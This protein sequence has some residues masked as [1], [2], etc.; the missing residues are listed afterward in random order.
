MD[1]VEVL[2]ATMNQKDH[3][4]LK[5]MNIQTE[6][7][8][9]NQCDRN[10]IEEFDFSGRKC[11]YLNFNERGVGLNRN[12][13]LMRA[14][15]D[16]CVFADDDMVFYDGYNEIVTEAFR[17]IE[18]AD[19]LIFNI[20]EDGQTTRRKNTR[21]K[22]IG[23]LNYLNYGAARI[24][25]RRQDV[26]YKGISFNLNFGGGTRH[27]CGE[28]T[29]FLRECLRKRV[30][31]YAVPVSIAKLVEKRQSTWFQG[32]NE[33]YFFDSGI[34]LSIAHPILCHLLA[35][36]FVLKHKEYRISE[37]DGRFPVIKAY[38]RGIFYSYKKKWRKS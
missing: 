5:T 15:G 12:N 7:I 31:I 4:L 14:A 9:A 19:V 37:I 21:T 33:K 29:L 10:L 22:R 16:F 36:Y 18:K 6:A 25:I 26:L 11:I 34:L 28:D 13:A 24:V 8:V 27:S 3:S 38:E 17:K 30:K 35:I 1:K 20:D 32:F 2:V 23:I